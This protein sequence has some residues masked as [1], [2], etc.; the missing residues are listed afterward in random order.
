MTATRAAASPHRTPDRRVVPPALPVIA[1]A[2]PQFLK[3]HHRF[4]NWRWEYRPD[5]SQKKPW[6]KP[7]INPLS[8][9]YA[10]TDDPT[11][12]SSFAEA[13]AAMETS[14]WP[15]IGFQ[16]LDTKNI[17]VLDLDNC[18]D[19]ASHEIAPWARQVV[20]MVP[21][22]WEFSPSGTGLRGVAR[23]R[24][25]GP[26][27]KTGNAEMYDGSAGRYVTLTGHHLAGSASNVEE[28]QDGIH[29]AY[30]CFFPQDVTARVTV[31]RAFRAVRLDD[32][33]V[34][35]KACAARNGESF[36]RLWSGD[37][38]TYASHS[39]AD[40]ALCARLVFWTCADASAVD[41]LF[42]QSGLFRPK[43][44]QKHA[45]DGRTYG[46]MTI[47]KAVKRGSISSQ[48]DYRFR[49]IGTI[50]VKVHET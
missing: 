5:T 50:S 30:R 19:A 39:E 46:A 29:A 4:C 47:A 23:G 17:V 28:C 49:T 1:Q 21:S 38:S 40:L 41:R 35:S 27:S 15:G 25:P 24:K 2:I 12:W 32:A 18:I 6:T 48:A 16:L 8:G 37:W 22:Y 20:A 43:W 9:G 31:A 34:V 45:G 11:T 42:R 26:R 7:P 14:G 33:T 36:K 10:R 44:D 13:L 3:D